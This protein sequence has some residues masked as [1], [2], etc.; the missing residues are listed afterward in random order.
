MTV[1]ILIALALYFVQTLLPVSFR[2]RGSPVSMGPRDVMPEASSP[3]VGRSERALV[4]VGEA[5]ILFLPLALLTLDQ[6]GAVIGAQIFVLARLAH[7]PLYL[8][9]ITYLRTIA[10]VIS[11]VGLIIMALSLF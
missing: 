10:W 7:L 5:M 8:A 1:W 11:L 6:D 3:L 4:N 9:G 2:Y